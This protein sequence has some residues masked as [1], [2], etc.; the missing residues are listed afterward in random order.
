MAVFFMITAMG[1]VRH[2]P[3]ITNPVRLFFAHKAAAQMSGAEISQ[4]RSTWKS[5]KDADKDQVNG[6][7]LAGTDMHFAMARKAFIAAA[8]LRRSHLEHAD[9][10]AADLRWSDLRGAT[11]VGTDLTTGGP[12]RH[13]FAGCRPEPGPI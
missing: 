13:R 4:R 1:V 10:E 2:E 8:D 11:L 9:F 7:L 6:A 12:A 5:G 3:P